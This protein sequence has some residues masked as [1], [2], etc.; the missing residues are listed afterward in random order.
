[1]SVVICE[2]AVLIWRKSLV[3]AFWRDR[4]LCIASVAYDQAIG[5]RCD[6]LLEK[7]YF[8]KSRGSFSRPICFVLL[9]P[10]Q[11][12]M[13]SRWSSIH[14][15]VYRWYSHI[16]AC[17]TV[18]AKTL[19]CLLWTIERDSSVVKLHFA[20]LIVT[21]WIVTFSDHS[22]CH[23]LGSLYQWLPSRN[24]HLLCSHFL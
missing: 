10:G 7:E 2:N 1:M 20:S 24:G 11:C 3:F 4:F 15:S 17:L 19:S 12:V 16:A 13:L 9:L 21:L 23:F 5:G 22:P 14:E 8:I 6:S 18:W